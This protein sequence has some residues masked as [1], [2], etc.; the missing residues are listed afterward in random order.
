MTFTYI[1]LDGEMSGTEINEGARLIQIGLSL[2]EAWYEGYI[3]PG[4]MSWSEE[5]AAVH[6]IS[7]DMLPTDENGAD[8]DLHAYQFL[9]E[10]GCDP[11]RRHSTIAV[12]WNV[13]SFD[14]PFV[15][16]QL[17]KVYSLFSRR[18]VDLNSLCFA[19]DG[20]DNLNFDSWK[21]RSKQYAIERIGYED[22]HNAQWDARMS[23]FCFYY[24]R[25]NMHA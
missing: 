5:A 25:E 18:A 3:N 20:K 23:L 9:L 21:K 4:E 12:G 7:R 1:G 16:L 22:A 14:M 19:L 17:P 10:Q 13:A 8:I 11:K 24:L 6:N 15:K 2:D